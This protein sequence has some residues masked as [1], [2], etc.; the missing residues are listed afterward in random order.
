[1]TD[2]TRRYA[3]NSTLHASDKPMPRFNAKR[4]AQREAEGRVY[5]P[6]HEW[7]R[8]QPCILFDRPGHVCHFPLGRRFI[9]SHH[10]KSVGS[11]GEDENNTLPVDPILHDE[12][13]ALGL[14]RMCEKYGLD[15]RS[16]ACEVTA[17]FGREGA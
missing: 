1:M 14:T 17:R 5:G 7:T 2:R 12:F 16:L 4:R 13:H 11:G 15:F 10:V 6:L 3:H 8:R 9:E